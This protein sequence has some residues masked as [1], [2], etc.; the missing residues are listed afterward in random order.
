MLDD[1]LGRP[2]AQTPHQ[3]LRQVVPAVAAIGI[4]ARQYEKSWSV[5][6]DDVPYVLCLGERRAAALLFDF[7]PQGAQP[8]NLG[9]EPMRFVL[10]ASPLG[11]PKERIA[12]SAGHHTRRLLVGRRLRTR[13]DARNVRILPGLR[14]RFGILGLATLLAEFGLRALTF[15]SVPFLLP[16][17]DARIHPAASSLW[18]CMGDASPRGLYTVRARSARLDA[19]DAAFSTKIERACGAMEDVRERR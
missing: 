6:D 16:L 17:V 9:V 7:Q 3:R 19:G 2:L 5:G 13:D 12:R 15:L 14:R 18:P 11:E 10:A 4:A 1:E 8:R